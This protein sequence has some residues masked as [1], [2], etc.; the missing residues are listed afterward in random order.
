MLFYTSSVR[1]E[2]HPLDGF[3][4]CRAD[5]TS[6]KCQRKNV[7]WCVRSI[8][9]DW[10]TAASTNLSNV[11]LHCYFVLLWSETSNLT[12]VNR[13]QNSNPFLISTKLYN[14]DKVSWS[15][16]ESELLIDLDIT[17]TCIQAL[18]SIC[19]RAFRHCVM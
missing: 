2:I 19:A 16:K 6:I 14:A 11:C 4:N 17:S 18:C 8:R 15:M 7:D 5:V 9:H 13:K 12:Y 10:A 3:I 1:K